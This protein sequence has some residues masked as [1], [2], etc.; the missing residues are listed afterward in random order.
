LAAEAN[1]WAGKQI[2]IKKERLDWE[3]TLIYLRLEHGFP[4]SDSPNLPDC[5]VE[6]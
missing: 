3:S 4:P 2:F 1:L 5:T 6:I